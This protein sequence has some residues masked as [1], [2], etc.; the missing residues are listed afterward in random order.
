MSLLAKN[1]PSTKRKKCLHIYTINRLHKEF[2]ISISFV[3]RSLHKDL[4]ICFFD[5]SQ[6]W[7]VF[8]FIEL[9]NFFP[10]QIQFFRLTILSLWFHSTTEYPH[11]L[12]SASFDMVLKLWPLLYSERIFSFFFQRTNVYLLCKRPSSM[13]Y[14][15]ENLHYWIIS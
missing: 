6:F 8:L 15:D 11:L 3:Q 5:S 1:F 14:G 13:K 4:V 12:F 10:F 7:P 2:E 9:K